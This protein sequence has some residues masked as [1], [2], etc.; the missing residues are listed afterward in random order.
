MPLEL[1]AHFQAREGVIDQNL[2]Q[3]LREKSMQHLKTKAEAPS[4]EQA[5]Q[6]KDP[7]TDSSQNSSIKGD[8]AQNNNNSASSASDAT[9]STASSASQSSKRE[10]LFSVHNF[11]INIDLFNTSVPSGKIF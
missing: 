9:D 1:L 5:E 4:G 2:L 3:E 7:N 8:G 6:P 10:D 11:D